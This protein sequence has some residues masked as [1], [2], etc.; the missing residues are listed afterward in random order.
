MLAIGVLR[1][2]ET[3]Q[4]QA[5]L[6]ERRVLSR[7]TGWGGLPWA[8][9]RLEGANAQRVRA[10]RLNEILG[11]EEY[12]SARASVNN[13]HYTSLEVIEA[14]WA[15]VRRLGFRG[16]R[17]LE[18]AAGVGYFLGAMP[19]TLAGRSAVTAI[20]IDKLSS[21]ILRA[22]YAGYGVRVLDVG[23]E[24]A[25]L[26][27]DFFDL[28][29][30]NVPFGNYKVP[31]TRYVPY[32]DFLIHDYFFGRALEAVRPGG[33]IAFITSAGTLDKWDER[34]RDFL[35]ARAFLLAAIRLPSI[36]FKSIANTEVTTDIVFLRKLREGEG[37][38][39]REW[40]NLLEIPLGHEA[41]AASP[42]WRKLYV[43]RWFVAKP[44]YVVGRLAIGSN[45]YDEVCTCTLDGELAPALAKRIDL[46][47]ERAYQSAKSARQTPNEAATQH[48][49]AS[50]L[51]KPGSYVLV[52]GALC[53]C[54]GGEFVPAGERLADKAAPRI[55]G[56]IAIRDAARALVAAQAN[57]EEE[58]PL[59]RLRAALNRAYDEF[60][61]RH[62][63]LHAL[64]N[65]AAFRGDPGLPLLL[66][67]EH[68]DEE[69]A[70]ARK[71][72][73]FERRT[74]GVV[75]R[76]ERCET[77][78]E[79]LAASI[80]EK[81]GIDLALMEK[82]LGRAQDEFV[83]GL[84]EAGT[85]FRN[86]ETGEWET[87]D[88]YLSG[89]VR[90]KLAFAE[91]AGPEFT[92]NAQALRA[93]LP[94][95]LLPHD[96]G[97]RL[98]SSWIPASDY[99][100]FLNG[101]FDECENNRVSFSAQ[102]GAWNVDLDYRAAGSVAATQTY[103]T[104]R[105]NAVELFELAL[106]QVEPTVYDPD[107]DD[108]KKRRVNFPATIAA[109]EKQQLLKESF[110]DW[111]WSDPVRTARLV[112]L[113][114]DTFNC[115]V[116]RR[117]DGSHLV[118][119]G[120]SNMYELHPH[121]K[122]A[123][124]RVIAS[125]G[126]SLLA[127]AVGAGKAQPLDAK[128]LTPTGWCRMGDL[129]PGD[130]V[131]AGDGTPSLVEAVFPQ[132]E[133]E[134]YRV[135]FS[136]GASTECCGE[137]L[138]LTQTYRERGYAQ[139]ARKA[140][141]NWRCAEGQVRS[142]A[143]I[144]RTLIAPRLGGK[145][146]SIPIVGPV[147]F[148]PAAL[149][150]DPYLLGVLLGDGSMSADHVSIT[151]GDYELIESCR[152]LLP[153]NA[154][155]NKKKSD[156]RCSTWQIARRRTIGYGADM[157]P[158]PVVAALRAL[159]LQ[160]CKS[161]AKVIPN[162]YKL[163]A[164]D[165]RLALL[166]GL[167]DTD[168]TVSAKGHSIYFYTSS[169]RLADDVTFVVQSLGGLVRRSVKH[170]SY[171][172][173]GERRQGARAYVL[174][175]SLPAEVIPF[176]LARKASRVKPKTNYLPTRYIVSAE[177]AGRKPAQCIRVAHPSHLYVTDDFI[178]THNT[179]EMI[180]AGMELRRLG[181]A[182]KP[183][184]VVPNHM[185]YEF[186][187]E[188]LKAYPAANILMAGKEDL[189][190]DRRR[191]L[192]AR[193]AT[194]D[195]DAV[196]ITHASFERIKL[197]DAY[198][199]R[200]IRARVAEIEVALRSEERGRGNR[201]VKELERAKKNWQARLEKLAAPGKKDDHLI[202][203]QLGI[204]QLFVDEA[205]CFPY[206]MPVLTREGWVPIGEI[207][208]SRLATEVAS[209][210]LET[211]EIE[212]KPLTDWIT[213]RT[214]EALVRVTHEGGVLEC[215]A[216]HEIWTEEDGYIEAR[217]L[218]PAHH[219][220][221]LRKASK[222]QHQRGSSPEILRPPLCERSDSCSEVAACSNDHEHLSAVRQGVFVSVPGAG[223]QRKTPVLRQLVCSDMAEQ[224]PRSYRGVQLLGP[225]GTGTCMCAPLGDQESGCIRAHAAVESDEEPGNRREGESVT[226]RSDLSVARREWAA[227]EATDASGEAPR[228]SYGVRH[229]HQSGSREVRVVADELQGGSRCA[230]RDGCNRSGRANPPAEEVE[231][232]G[233]AQDLG[234]GRSRVVG[235]EVLEPRG[236]GQ[237]GAC[238]AEGKRVY[239][240]EVEDN[241]NFFAS[242]ILVSN[243]FKNLWRFTKLT[244]L[245]GLPN[246]NSER[247]FD[248]FLKTRYV[249]DKRGA[250]RGVALA[251]AT[252]VANSVAEF[253]TMQRYLQPRTLEAFGLQ[254]FD[255][256]AANFGEAV[257]A[258]E[259]APD[260]SGYRVHT[261]FA[262]FINVPELM[263]LFREVA[264]IRTRESLNLPLPR[265]TKEIVTAKASPRLKRFV[266]ELV[267]RAE[268]IRRG[269]V[270]PHEDN[271]LAV[272]TDGRKAALD[273]RLV[274]PRAPAA[275]GT[276]T[277]L[278]AQKVHAVWR[279][280]EK[281]HGT[282]LVFCDLGTP[283]EG[284]TF[285][286]YH[287]LRRLLAELGTPER[288][289]AFI[290]EYET[291]RA[292]QA[293]FQAVREGRVRVLVGS[294]QKLGI[295]TNVQTYLVALHH[296]DAPW[297]PADVEQREGR[298]LRQGNLNEEL[299]IFRY[300]TEGS[301]DAYVWQTLETKAR[302]IAQVMQG[303]TGLRS[304]E[305][306]EVAALT[307]AEVKA[308]A[309]GNPL[310]IEKAGVDAELAKLALVKSQ[311]DRQQWQNKMEITSLPARIEAIRRRIAGLESD[312]GARQD[313]SGDKFR[314]VIGGAA[315]QSRPE[316]VKR[317]VPYVQAVRNGEI[318]TIGAF[319]GFGL[320]IIANAV[321]K[322]FVL[323][324]NTEHETSLLGAPEG[325]AAL[326]EH[327]L[328][329]IDDTLG[330]ERAYLAATEKRLADLC[331]ETAKPF[332]KADRLA[333][334]QDRQRELEA[335]LDLDRGEMTAAEDAQA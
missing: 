309:S 86:P 20:E 220:W 73:I 12:E 285:S 113:Y 186:G 23:F 255:A 210:C 260:G 139:K 89:N 109:R 31:E 30:S 166:Q 247:A 298:G 132:G 320:E 2:L 7:Y 57:T 240:L 301:F 14:M 85:V 100:A 104:N 77:P 46:L 156:G 211:G 1:A 144:R 22:L 35:A 270:P 238:R 319:A 249:M 55:R 324:G 331:H 215:T 52:N 239:C 289:V 227:D 24:R 147:Q 44:Q 167:L 87:K 122:D 196:L 226:S 291:D 207:V 272:T 300:V 88:A 102:A 181:K 4:R 203:E 56:M 269:H 125:D 236:L 274:D 90:A 305:D 62:G 296:L 328:R 308:I 262:R 193:I 191:T 231:I 278:C 222:S 200:F 75:R 126:N 205:H 137:H 232:P 98:G 108:A 312:L 178:V 208:E 143:E 141:R 61:A 259:L 334:L 84:R 185:L 224:S 250:D 124:W 33:L 251:T 119:P 288:E 133:K 326:L 248:M 307:Y 256:W 163:A 253:W 177:P 176:R 146:H 103:G 117:Y 45:G 241:D 183:C 192:L 218:T 204:D 322:R 42:G 295:G 16:G 131:I 17:I 243:C 195:W 173:N 54:E 202:F 58:E 283:T 244:R 111:L 171:T 25:K 135:T 321:G 265:A 11:E 151:S 145:N 242:G 293:L 129:R 26:P 6:D 282:Q 32:R 290:H 225:G 66:S 10:A 276:K 29:I 261:R 303:D 118:L 134:I 235:I 148:A 313:T 188:F 219:L 182:A 271:M 34:V 48:A 63:Y 15:G 130:L 74:V 115:M 155:F 284:A 199:A 36:A 263:A 237:S 332:E 212:W 18:P 72:D 302:F 257:T 3:E 234:V 94:A 174:C 206:G 99:E 258:L 311:W 149:P 317:L 159:G 101:L 21:R 96:I 172:H 71:A 213:N 68:W 292:K 9:N 93:V 268:A 81:G 76:I 92:Q 128:V 314:I 273:M 194:G 315:C 179:L 216:D 28:A 175:L 50:D 316:A 41:R 49:L 267:A 106:N 254:H 110:K 53:V 152:P 306:V 157:E 329:R 310:V 150:V 228:S 277:Q 121:Q 142:L 197:S 138:W 217:S 127:H 136:D 297:R 5:S 286:V 40:N 79:A 323:K 112:R 223:A 116:S 221:V 252:P 170:P 160:G 190:G 164:P 69:A 27:P 78:E 233:Q 304:V 299:R 43:N 82:L 51:P 198:V 140:A 214:E 229:Q 165:Q 37:G 280:T 83:P 114:N 107:P 153:A 189:D 327:A 19:P 59:G 169:D 230:V 266:R 60:V 287:E 8:F 325:Y 168:G 158:N 264:D 64:A 275:E 47:P 187:A 245:A 120:F 330:E 13:A 97:G 279:E 201:I 80:H 281:V 95:D 209:V 38:N 335:A 333:W 154:R 184:Y 161:A 65:V 123:M 294:T 67:L 246:S 91:A 39:G 162:A 105:V 70:I 318:R 180:C